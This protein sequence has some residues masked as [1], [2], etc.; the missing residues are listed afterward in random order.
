MIVIELLIDER[1]SPSTSNMALDGYCVTLSSPRVSMSSWLLA[2]SDFMENI[3]GVVPLMPV[4][5]DSILI[6]V[7][8]RLSSLILA[9]SPMLERL[10]SLA[11]LFCILLVVS[12]LSTLNWNSYIT[13]LIDKSKEYSPGF[14]CFERGCR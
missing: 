7:L 6:A 11:I 5:S 14:I 10:I 1:S 4:D 8:P 13:S 2:S 12:E 9:V 3:T